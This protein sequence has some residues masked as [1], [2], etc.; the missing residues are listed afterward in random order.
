MNR[1]RLSVAMCTYNGARFLSEQLESIAVQTR[2][3]DELVVCDD[4]S[5]DESVEII[6]SLAD[7]APF[8]VRLEI[9][10]KNLGSTKNFEKA[11]GLCEGDIIALADQ[12]DVWKPQK[13]DVLSTIL[14]GHPGAGY[15]FS[16][17]ELMDDVGR[18]TGKGLWTSLRI[19]AARID[20]FR[21]TDQFPILL[22]SP[23]ATGATMVFRASLRSALLPISRHLVHDYWISAIASS[24]GAFGIPVREKLIQYREHDGQQIGPLSKSLI[25]KV[26]QAR[27]LESNQY[28]R[29]AQGYEDLRGRLLLGAADGR[30]YPSSYMALVE[31]KI[32]HLFRRA[33]ARSTR[34]TG[35]V[36]RVLSEVVTGRYGRF[37][38]SWRAVIKDLCF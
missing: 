30:A 12:D 27:R 20:Q 18:S 33:A 22:G 23:M 17:A 19:S 28:D 1:Q 26:K 5:V 21:G 34:G 38:G 2:L 6:R 31:E 32:L 3:P 11:I 9:N 35:K 7:H 25:E 29:L 13:L 4:G 36:R 10:E 37:S 8:P 16:D 15:A 24:V 14:E